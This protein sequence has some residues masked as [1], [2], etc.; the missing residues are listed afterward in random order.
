MV[1]ICTAM[2]RRNI[3]SKT[4][5]CCHYKN[6]F[7][8][9]FFFSQF[10]VSFN[11]ITLLKAQYI[12]QFTHTLCLCYFILCFKIHFFSLCYCLFSLSSFSLSLWFCLVFFLCFYFHAFWFPAKF[13]FRF[14]KVILKLLWFHVFVFVFVFN[15]VDLKEKGGPHVGRN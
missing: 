14:K 2:D 4:H 6:H 1:I 11:S 12:F 3:S 9:S 7:N 5:R 13:D 15:F 8:H 10:W